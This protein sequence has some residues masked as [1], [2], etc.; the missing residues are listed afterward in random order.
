M[1]YVLVGLGN[2]GVEYENSRHNT[3]RIILDSVAKRNKFTE[4]DKK[5]NINALVSDGKIGKDKVK[6]IFPETFMNKSGTSLKT[7]ITSVKK[8]EKLIVVYDD[9]DLPL[10]E[11]K[12][13]FGRGS[14]GHKGIESVTR[15]VKTKNFLRIRVGISP[16]ARGK[17]KVKKPKGEEKVIDFIMGSFK[18]NELDIL[19]SVSHQVDD[20]LKVL[21]SK[22]KDKAMNEFN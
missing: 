16:A 5:K 11:F 21:I 3:G 17:A 8:A 22:G 19:E 6:I 4:F 10:G 7:L 15:S 9:L 1:G 20:A 18:K 13:S 2:P 14:G 12:I